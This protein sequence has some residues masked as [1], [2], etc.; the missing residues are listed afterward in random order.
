[1]NEITVIGSRCGRFAP[2]LDALVTR[3]IDPRPLIDG[4]FP[5]DDGLAAFDA[6]KSPL[7]FKILLRAP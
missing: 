5:L 1:V 2:A 7:N 6:A 4:I 3:K